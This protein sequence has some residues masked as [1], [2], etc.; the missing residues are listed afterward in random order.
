MK[1][2][3][4]IGDLAKATGVKIVTIRYYEQAGL[5]PAP[6]RTEGNYRTYK[7]E[8]LRRLQF[9]RRLR[10]LGFGLERVRDL[11]RLASDG[12]QACDDVDRMT[13]EHLADVE[14]KIRDLQKLASELRR[15]SRCCKGGGQIAD[16]RIV[17]ALSPH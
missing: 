12:N 2:G 3:M 8:H 16:C 5:M 17:E 14:E 15:L 1:A 11:L 6:S 13:H 10:D 4:T 7:P 9:I